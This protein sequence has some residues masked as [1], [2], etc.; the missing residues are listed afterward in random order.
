MIEIVGGRSGYEYFK[1]EDNYIYTIA[2]FY[3]RMAVYN[4]VEGWQNKQF[5]G[6][7]EFTLTFG[8]YKVN[9]TVPEDHIVGAT[10]TL[11]NA[12]S[13]LTQTKKQI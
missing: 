12:S 8:D 6:N 13:V 11:T 4:D 7:G 10:G 1:D 3:P 9:I 5:L 2:Q